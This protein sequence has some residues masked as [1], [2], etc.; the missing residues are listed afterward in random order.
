MPDSG[1]P[2]RFDGAEVIPGQ[3]AC[4]LTDRSSQAIEH[5]HGASILDGP[6]RLTAWSEQCEPSMRLCEEAGALRLSA[7]LR[8]LA[9]GGRI[10]S[11]RHTGSRD[12]AEGITFTEPLCAIGSAA[13]HDVPVGWLDAFEPP[14]VAARHEQARQK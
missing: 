7:T 1:P 12:F 6:S 4:G 10:H 11:I 8:H 5:R 13:N 14:S 2:G 3:P 9:R